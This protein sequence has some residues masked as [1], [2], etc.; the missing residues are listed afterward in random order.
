MTLINCDVYML[1]Y[2][3]NYV[4][5][6][7]KVEFSDISLGTYNIILKIVIKRPGKRII[8]RRV[9][10]I[11]GKFLWIALLQISHSRTTC[12]HSYKCSLSMHIIIGGIYTNLQ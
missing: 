10:H 6:S 9:L 1:M 8:E 2:V 7:G 3:Y 4:G 11:V 5:I 12:S